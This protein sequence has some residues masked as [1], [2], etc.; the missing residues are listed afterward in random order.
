M[1]LSWDEW[2]RAAVL[3]SMKQGPAQVHNA[4]K[5][6]SWVPLGPKP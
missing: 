2:G 4:G 5:L 3:G 6:Q 1:G